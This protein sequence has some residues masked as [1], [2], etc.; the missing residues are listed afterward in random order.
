MET[1]IIV[2][3]VAVLGAVAFTVISMRRPRRPEP[4]QELRDKVTAL[5]G[6]FEEATKAIENMRRSSEQ[7]T[8]T[9]G[10]QV[11]S[12]TQ[13]ME[14]LRAEVARVQEQVRHVVSFQD[15]FRS[16]KLRGNWGEYSLESAL[17]QYFSGGS[18]H[19]QHMFSAGEGEDQ[20]TV[21]A[22]LQLP[23]GMLLPIDSKFN[24]ENFQKMVQADND[25]A[26]EGFRKQFLSDVKKKVDEIASKYIRV[27]EG[28][29]DFAL[30]YV[31]AEAVYYEVINNL[32]EADV[33]S[34]ARGKK[35]ILCSPNTFYLTVSAVQH[36][37]RDSQFS[38]ETQNIMKKLSL[39]IKDSEKLAEEFRLLGKHLSATR[40]SYEDADKR[41]GLL[42]DRTQKVL[43]AGDEMKSLE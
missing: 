12:F 15:I 3:L 42:V 39:V 31:P 32:G 25:I 23:N 40:S 7:S 14:Q 26:K 10:S 34:Y 2:L 28:T 1:V 22:V 6:R 24:W 35:V 18:W 29:T 20:V 36:W 33:S 11:Q 8:G 38:R 17:G 5:T 16:P 19:A 4:D 37:F 27:H 41:L 13:G 21:D 43:E 9:V 30:M